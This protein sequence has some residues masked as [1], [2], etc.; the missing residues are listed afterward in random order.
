MMFKKATIIVASIILGVLFAIFIN[1]NS[2]MNNMRDPQ[3][4]KEAMRGRVSVLNRDYIMQTVRSAP[5]TTPNLKPATYTGC[6]VVPWAGVKRQFEGMEF[7]GRDCS[8]TVNSDQTVEVSFIDGGIGTLV[9]LERDSDT[10]VKD[11]SDNEVLLMQHLNGEV[12]SATHTGYDND[13][14]LNYASN[15]AG[16]FIKACLL[17]EQPP[18]QY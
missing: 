13:G 18:C 17:S 8:I 14:N 9:L 16:D 5:F 1:C 6:E 15:G 11:I 4:M 2:T 10:L 3:M 12:V 7:T